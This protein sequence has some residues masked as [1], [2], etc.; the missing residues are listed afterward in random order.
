MKALSLIISFTLVNSASLGQGTIDFTNYVPWSRPPVDA[1]FTDDRGIRLSGLNYVAQLY[2]GT[3]REVLIPVGV[4]A[5]F[6][7]GTGSGYFMGGSV[8]I[9]FITFA[10]PAW[11]Q[12][13]AW[14][15]SA[16]S[17]F[18]DAAISGGWTGISEVFY[19]PSTG[20]GGV[21]PMT[22]SPLIGLKYPG[23]P[24]I[25]RQP[26]PQR[27]RSGEKAALSVVATG[28]VAVSYQWHRDKTG[29]TTNPIPGATNASFTT[30]PLVID[31][32]FWVKV[33]TSVGSANSSAALITVLPANAARLSL[34]VVSG[35]PNLS[36]DGAVGTTYRIE[37]KPEL[38]NGEWITLDSVSLASNPLMF[39]DTTATGVAARFYR[40]VIP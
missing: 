15:T 38:S 14:E 4:T 5:P 20:H 23:N 7:S 31:T 24:I 29:D 26:Q 33:T 25:V 32:R 8:E 12:V 1:P 35:I 9:P 30:P 6:R 34:R 36:I 39:M 27:V 37:Y 19:V 11:V 28:G 16:G 40:V 21:N 17:T 18:E 10:G 3:G 22:P 13:R 2:A